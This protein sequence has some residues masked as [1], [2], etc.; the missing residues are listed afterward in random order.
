MLKKVYETLSYSIFWLNSFL[1]DQ[2][3]IAGQTVS[4]FNFFV[5]VHHCK[6]KY[7]QSYQLFTSLQGIK[8]LQLEFF[9]L[10]L[11]LNLSNNLN[12]PNFIELG[13]IRPRAQSFRNSPHTQLGF[14]FLLLSGSNIEIIERINLSYINIILEK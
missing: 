3:R 2:W 11:L 6:N 5:E 10:T 7:L 13:I 14:F 9:F 12:S 1:C 8:T 4:F